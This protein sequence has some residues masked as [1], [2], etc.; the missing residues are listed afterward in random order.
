MALECDKQADFLI[1]YYL[2][3]VNS[4]GYSGILF[5]ID[6]RL[7]PGIEHDFSASASCIS[8][9]LFMCRDE[10]PMMYWRFV[11]NLHTKRSL[12]INHSA[13]EQRGLRTADA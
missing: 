3:A 1:P 7:Y 12:V 4:D 11:S 5:I 6:L 2:L 9:E 13:A 10:T 8:F